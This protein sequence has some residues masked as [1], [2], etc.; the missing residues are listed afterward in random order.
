MTTVRE[1]W[2]PEESLTKRLDDPLTCRELAYLRGLLADP[3][4]PDG[5]RLQRAVHTNPE[6]GA[7]LAGVFMYGVTGDGEDGRV[8]L[9][10][11]GDPD[12]AGGAVARLVTALLGYGPRLLR[13]LDRAGGDQTADAG[14][15]G[16]RR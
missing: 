15:G 13:Q 5:D 9:V 16:G 7:R 14:S 1:Q 11:G 2:P 3:A 10:C 6:T 8:L 4:L 12:G